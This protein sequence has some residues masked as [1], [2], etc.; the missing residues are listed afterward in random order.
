MAKFNII[1]GTS[2]NDWLVGSSLHNDYIIGGYGNDYLFGYNGDDILDGGQGND[3]LYGGSGNDTFRGGTGADHLNGGSGIDT[4]TYQN[5]HSGV[6]I[7]LSTNTA[8]GSWAEGDT[9]HSIENLTGSYYRDTL[10]GS[11]DA[12]VIKGLGGNDTI[13]GY[14]GDD[15]LEG[16]TGIDFIR[17]G[18]GH[19][20]IDGGADRDTL[21]GGSGNDT[22][23]GGHGSDAH[24]GDSGTD[25]VTY[26]NSTGRVVLDLENGGASGDALGDTFNGIENV[27]GTN[28]DDIIFADSNNNVLEGLGGDD[29]FYAKGY[30]NQFLGGAGS[31]WVSYAASHD[32]VIVTLQSGALTTNDD[33]QDIENLIGTEGA[34]LIGGDQADNI[35]V[36]GGGGDRIAGFGGDDTLVGGAG[37][38]EFYFDDTQGPEAD[39]ITDFETGADV[40]DLRATE[41]NDFNDLTNGGSRYMEQLGDDTVIHYYDHTITLLNVDSAD[42]NANDFLFA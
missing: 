27:I 2:K 36:G 14:G 38:D 42:L 11:S 20:T 18:D 5:A 1:K 15:T 19:D 10:K 37:A 6:T 24:Y 28:Y 13:Y 22:F 3:R 41:F 17:G 35:L 31:D 32:G 39:V 33:F 26:A 40:I 9:F 25:T 16:G 4:A 8:T 34:D 12:N 29:T 23:I 30:G 21:I 7:N